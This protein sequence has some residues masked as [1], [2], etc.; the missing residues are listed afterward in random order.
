MELHSCRRGGGP[1]DYATRPAGRSIR[2]CGA[3][4]DRACGF[5]E[6]RPTD[7][8]LKDP[9][10]WKLVGQRIARLP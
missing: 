10:D 8:A 7:V 4:T 6:R 1:I 9:K 5:R 3:K 2:P